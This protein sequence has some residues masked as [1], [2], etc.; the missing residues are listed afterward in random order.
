M[1]VVKYLLRSMSESEMFF[2]AAMVG[3]YGR[4]GSV[5]SGKVL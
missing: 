2:G 3:G 4:N 1:S 5:Q